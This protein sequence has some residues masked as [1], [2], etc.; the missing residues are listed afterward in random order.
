LSGLGFYA[1]YGC[2]SLITVNYNAINSTTKAP[3]S[4]VGSEYSAI[5]SGC[6]SLETVN[7]GEK[8][9]YIPSGIFWGCPAITSLTLPE[10]L[11][12]IGSYAFYQCSSISGELVIPE[13]VTSIGNYAFCYCSSITDINIPASISEL[14][15]YV[16]YNCTA[17][18]NITAMNPAPPLCNNNTFD[19]VNIN[20]CMLHVPLGSK[21]LYEKA[22]GWRDFYN[23]LDDIDLR[24]VQ[25]IDFPAFTVKTYG[26]ETITLPELTDA[27]LPVGYESSNTQ[28]ATVSGNVLTIVGAGTADIIATQTG[29]NSY[30]PAEPVTQTLTVNPKEII[31]TDIAIEAIPQQVYAGEAIS[32]DATITDK[33]APLLKDVDYSLAYQDNIHVGTATIIITGTGN[34]TGERNITFEIDKATQSIDFPA[35]SE[36]TYGDE[37]ITLPATTDKGLAISYE[38]ANTQV[39]TVSGNVLTIVGV[40]TTDIVA[41]QPGDNNYL[42][43]EPVKQTLTV[44]PK[45]ITHAD[46]SATSISQQVYT[47][48]EFSPEP[49]LTDKNAAMTKD[50][51]YS[52]TYRDNINAETASIIITGF[53]NYTGER[54]ITFE[55]NKAAQS[56]GFPSIPS[57]NIGD[58]YALQ[59]VASSG[60]PVVYS[61]NDES[62]A[63]IT[64][65]VIRILKA[66]EVVVT[67]SQ[68]GNTNYYPADAVQ[69]TVSILPTSI[70]EVRNRSTKAYPTA[71]KPMETVYVE[72]DGS[73][74]MLSVFNTNGTCINS[75]QLKGNLCPVSAPATPGVYIFR[76]AY[77]NGE[78]KNIRIIVGR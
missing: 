9:Q 58:E 12:S 7:I 75:L 18:S 22:R 20:T 59:A 67:A 72:T 62:V 15:E 2:T 42:A 26:D 47:G 49:S 65:N 48:V 38:S 70:E 73:N 71:V 63:E 27:G 17:L 53:G 30:F 64:Q 45:N 43:A 69:Q 33:N 32:P 11:T 66:G 74:A 54:N 6:T 8:V 21:E 13:T 5:F 78:Y 60:L 57:L 3:N 19:G 25:A 68:E 24:E 51:D 40:G 76:I 55:I 37:T 31:H 4:S 46:I 36:K 10:S 61:V 50:V 14:G 23:I 56:I 16:F 39:A 34:Y 28:V 41:T 29:N 77:Q 35:F 1:F 44:D 52:L